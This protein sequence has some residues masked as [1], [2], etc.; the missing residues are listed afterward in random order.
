MSIPCYAEMPS[1]SRLGINEASS[2]KYR[3]KTEKSRV[4][5]AVYSLTKQDASHPV[6]NLKQF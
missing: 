2:F 6:K 4:H 5:L 1:E 3:T